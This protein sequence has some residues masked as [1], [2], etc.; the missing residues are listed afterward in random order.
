[1]TTSN[2]VAWIVFGLFFIWASWGYAFRTK[3]TIDD[4]TEKVARGGWVNP[5][6]SFYTRR[7]ALAHVAG[8]IAQLAGFL[9]IILGVVGLIRGN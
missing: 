2:S 9:M 8:L 6:A 3:K 5:Q 7:P 1:M 4:M